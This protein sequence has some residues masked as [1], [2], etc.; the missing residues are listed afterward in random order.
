M[1]QGIKLESRSTVEAAGHWLASF[2][3]RRSLDLTQPELCLGLFGLFCATRVLGS[4]PST[5]AFSDSAQSV[6]AA[7]L[8]NW[9]SH[10][11][12][13][14]NEIMDD[15][16]AWL[17]SAV[18]AAPDSPET[19][20]YRN[21]VQERWHS[22]EERTALNSSPHQAV[23]CRFLSA[24]LDGSSDLP[25]VSSLSGCLPVLPFSQYMAD[26]A[27]IQDTLAVLAILSAH[28]RII[29]HLSQ[30]EV[31][32]VQKALPFWTFYYVK[33]RRLDNVCPLARTLKY[34]R[35]EAVPEYEKAVSY[36]LRQARE[37]GS[38]SNRD[39]SCRFYSNLHPESADVEREIRLPLTV[40]G[41][42]TLLEC[43]HSSQSPFDDSSILTNKLLV[44]AR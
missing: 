39:L 10:Q 7:L 9:T 25:D 20:A 23:T 44:R 12:D 33:E 1:L 27:T 29:P 2:F 6:I 22:L 34:L 3:R 15:P 4:S 17:M 11:D 32:F 18:F 5:V 14:R 36:I 8:E 35:M 30:A 19:A 28:G 21:A 13:S 38:F 41:I 16:S 26:D 40:S 31:E 43:L 42:W 37:D 24:L